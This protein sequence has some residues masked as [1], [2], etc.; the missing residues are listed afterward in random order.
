MDNFAV[1]EFLKDK[2]V[3]VIPS[4]WVFKDEAEVC[5]TQFSA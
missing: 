2:S 1:V 3:A 5:L 4:K